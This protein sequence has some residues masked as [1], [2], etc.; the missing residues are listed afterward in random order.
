MG[1][2]TVSFGLVSIPVKLF[3][4]GQSQAAISFNMLHKKCGSR[5][6][7]Q[8]VC[9]TEG[10]VVPREETVKGFEFAKGQ[11]VTFTEEELEALEA[12][13]TETIEITE[14][15]PLA[16]VDPVFFEKAY[17]LAPEKGGE[18]AYRLLSEAM[19]TTGRA[20]LAK[21]AARG[22]QYLVLVRPREGR[23]VLQQLRYADEVR[24]IEEVP[25]ADAEVKEPELALAVKLVEQ[26]AAESFRPEQYEDEVKKR[27]EALIERKVAGQEVVA[28]APPAE[29]GGQIIDL[30]EALKASLAKAP[31][32]KAAPAAAEAQPEA[33]QRKEAKRAEARSG[34]IGKSSKKVS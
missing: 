17:Y 6:K 20:A 8:Y 3:P 23:L 18:K 28:A 2:A 22:K 32:P 21:Y 7:Q 29:G 25:I 5:L 9:S 15:V 12:V 4:A 11:Y 14:F 30:M 31:A 16:K 13:S 1:T 33:G 24:P 19:R 26:I 34:K 10:G 27:V